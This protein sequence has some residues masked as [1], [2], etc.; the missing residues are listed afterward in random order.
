M[1]IYFRLFVRMHLLM[2][3]YNF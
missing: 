1:F 2:N 3:C